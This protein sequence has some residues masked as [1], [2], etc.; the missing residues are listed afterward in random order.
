L[1]VL[2]ARDATELERFPV[3]SSMEPQETRALMQA[4]RSAKGS[5]DLI[6]ETETRSASEI[7]TYS[8]NLQGEPVVLE[9]SLQHR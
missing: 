5:K 7:G 2:F 1:I 8:V 3:K 4:V 6:V 9:I